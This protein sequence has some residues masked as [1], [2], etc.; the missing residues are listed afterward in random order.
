MEQQNKKNNQQ[1]NNQQTN[2]QKSTK[3]K[4]A[5]SF[6][7]IFFVGLGY[8]VGAGIYSLL[9]YATKYGGNFT[10]LSFIIGG[11]H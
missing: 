5:L 9:S 10:W 6:I 7:D 8:I 2:N 4:N 3:L 1:P 11:I